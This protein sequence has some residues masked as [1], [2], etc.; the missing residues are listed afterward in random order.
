MAHFLVSCLLLVKFVNVNTFLTFLNE[1]KGLSTNL[2]GIEDCVFKIKRFSDSPEY[3]DI[4][5]SLISDEYRVHT[6]YDSRNTTESI[7]LNFEQDFRYFETCVVNFIVKCDQ[8]DSVRRKS[9]ILNQRDTDISYRGKMF[10][11]W[12]IITRQP[13][14]SKLWAYDSDYFSGYR[15]FY[16]V[17]PIL[18]LGMGDK[19]NKL[20][21][22]CPYCTTEY[23]LL[24]AKQITILE[25]NAFQF[26]SA[27][28][29]ILFSAAVSAE[30]QCAG[31]WYSRGRL[32]SPTVRMVSSL[33]KD[34]NIT[35]S[36]RFT[37][38]DRMLGFYVHWIEVSDFRYEEIN[39][40]ALQQPR[41]SYLIYCNYEVRSEELLFSVWVSPFQISVWALLAISFV[42]IVFVSIVPVSQLYNYSLKQSLMAQFFSCLC[43]YHTQRL[44]LYYFHYWKQPNIQFKRWE[45]FSVNL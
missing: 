38:R 7:A 18:K 8:S 28:R 43:R 12:I 25:V 20:Y 6:L 19:T 14:P 27:W 21:Y 10:S 23:M 29:K 16:L 35:F 11:T 30:I 5:E 34:L 2:V 9:Y 41:D 31:P 42:S 3:I 37:A 4:S 33:S 40:L 39:C 45:F 13:H 15:L 32:C 22:F 44:L 26:Q 1:S 17:V 24:P 36:R